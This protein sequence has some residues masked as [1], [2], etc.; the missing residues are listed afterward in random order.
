MLP[1]VAQQLVNAVLSAFEPPSS[2]WVRQAEHFLLLLLLF[3]GSSIVVRLG[4]RRAYKKI[5]GTALSGLTAIP[6]VSS[7][8]DA[9][10]DS[11]LAD[12]ERELL[13]DG[14]ADALLAIPPASAAASVL[15]RA[16]EQK[17]RQAGFTEGK[18]WGGIYHC[19]GE[20]TKLQSDVWSEFN[21]SNTL[22]PEVFP[23]TR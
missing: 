17:G 3:W 23:G 9:A 11:E 18:K 4:P 5:A 2:R 10:L 22:Y 21:C 15:A 6:G 20:L 12:I 13:G 8:V 1:M 14:D 7:L 16:R 19:E